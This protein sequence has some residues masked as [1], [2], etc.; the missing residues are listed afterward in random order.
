MKTN[1]KLINTNKQIIYSELSYKV[2]GAL[3]NVHNK[4]GSSYQEKYYQ[5]AIETE[6]KIQKIPFL[7]EK[8]IT[9]GYGNQGIGKYRPR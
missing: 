8:E 3:F 5:R 4:L 7:K 2:M 1:P 6:L 9:I